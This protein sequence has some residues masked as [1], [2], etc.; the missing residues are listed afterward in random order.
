MNN[1]SGRQWRASLYQMLEHFPIS[2]TD[3]TIHV[4]VGGSLCK[5]KT[6]RRNQYIQ[7]YTMLIFI[8]IKI[9][10]SPL[11]FCLP[12]CLLFM[13]YELFLRQPQFPFANL[14]LRSD[15]RWQ[16]VPPLSLASDW[17]DSTARSHQCSTGCW[18]GPFLVYHRADSPQHH[19]A[20][21]TGM[22]LEWSFCRVVLREAVVL[23]CR[24]AMAMWKK[25]H[26]CDRLSALP[27]QLVGIWCRSM[28]NRMKGLLGECL[29]R[30]RSTASQCCRRTRWLSLAVCQHVNDVRDAVVDRTGLLLLFLGE[31]RIRDAENCGHPMVDQLA[32]LALTV[33]L[34]MM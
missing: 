13:S 9:S 14:S 10:I 22:P 28:V 17:E 33:K 16:R 5:I 25:R 26:L 15:C 31:Q 3:L 21:S 20:L 4:F 24:V 1:V 30:S 29:L 23:L 8:Y 32:I 7:I 11:S 12:R 18:S 2:K 6:L 27:S 19:H 34:W